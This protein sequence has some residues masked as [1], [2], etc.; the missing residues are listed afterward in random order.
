MINA[1]IG[2]QWGD[3][4]K[5]K[6]VDLLGKNIDYTIRFQGGNNAGHTVVIGKSK[7]FFHLVPSGVFNKKTIGIISNGVII[8]P[9]VLIEELDMLKKAGVDADNKI[10]I[11]DRS[12]LILPYHKKMDT[13]LENARGTGGLGTTGRG[14]GPCYADKV[15]YN[16]IR[17]YELVNFD[18]FQKK[19]TFQAKIK[20][21]ILKALGEKPVN[22]Q[23]SINK[24]K[25]F[26]KRLL[27][28]IKNS[29]EKIQT[30]IFK[31]KNILLEGA[32]G[33]MLDVDWA[34]YPYCTGSNTIIGAAYAGSSIS[35]SQIDKIIGVV[36]AY[37]SRVG[38]GPLI[39]ETEKNLAHKIRE[40][41]GEYGT[42]TGRPRRIGW[43]DLEALKF[44]VSINKTDYIAL[45]KLDVLSGLKNI[46]VCKSY[47]YKGAKISYDSCGLK[48][49]EEIIPQYDILP[50]WD[51][52]ISQIKDFKKLP[53]NCINYV[54][55]IERQLSV[56]IKIV[57]V[58]P[59]RDA[60]IQI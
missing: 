48:E 28:L 25:Q 15:S 47:K 27:P 10:I 20:N 55:Y 3:E 13:A 7:F 8:D 41:G 43:L 29:Y 53:K 1:I 58:G 51:E 52:D 12:H 5:G 50:G 57:S 40:K 2:L 56:P 22:V 9:E 38:G 54:R 49:L 23:E 45:T 24:Y 46:K 59:A 17:M 18:L 36:K 33:T 39:S 32:Q 37:T 4:G 6:V 26:R 14:I 21:R 34:A 31:K 42:T 30:A 11:S 19:F 16:G 60:T 35:P 44:A